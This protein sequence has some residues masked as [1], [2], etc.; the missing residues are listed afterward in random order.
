METIFAV[1]ARPA[2]QVT[3][4]RVYA[5]SGS[6]LLFCDRISLVVITVLLVIVTGEL[7]LERCSNVV[8][9]PSSVPIPILNTPCSRV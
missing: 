4:I 7:I 5:P 3:D 9:Q 2:R 6:I 8:V 1:C